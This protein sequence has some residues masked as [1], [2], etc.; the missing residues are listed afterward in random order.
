MNGYRDSPIALKNY[1]VVTA[2]LSD[3]GSHRIQRIHTI[4]KYCHQ[5][6]PHQKTFSK[7]E[8]EIEKYNQNNLKSIKDQHLQGI[9]NIEYFREEKRMNFFFKLLKSQNEL[10][11]MKM[12]KITNSHGEL[13][14][15]IIDFESDL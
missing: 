10:S 13:I 3:H 5:D 15:T 8:E 9:N 1:V 2:P 14:L 4:L 6:V 7:L 12:S 11:K